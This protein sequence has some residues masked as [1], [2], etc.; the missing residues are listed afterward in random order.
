MYHTSLAFDN[1]TNEL[2]WRVYTYAN[3]YDQLRKIN[4]YDGTSSQVGIFSDDRLMGRLPYSVHSGSSGS[5][6]Q[7]GRPVCG[8]RC[9]R[10]AR[11]HAQMDKPFEDLR[12]RRHSESLTKVEIY[13]NNELVASRTTPA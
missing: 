12:P 11:M 10:D 1:E 5:S 2:Y 7:G 8:C 3:M 4:I 6:G 9:R 13:R